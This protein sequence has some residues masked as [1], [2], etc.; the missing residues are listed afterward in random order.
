MCVQ[1]PERIT[2]MSEIEIHVLPLIMWEQQLKI[3]AL[4]GFAA[5]DGIILTLLL[6]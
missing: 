6:I 3:C 4:A 5:F 1:L 2:Y